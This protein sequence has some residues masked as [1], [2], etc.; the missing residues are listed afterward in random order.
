V[1]KVDPALREEQC[2]RLAAVKAERDGVQVTTGLAALTE[3][4]GSDGPLMEPIIACV[5]ACATVGEIS[6]ALRSVWGEY[7]EQVVV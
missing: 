1:L 2:R 6:D 5:E 4:A 7:T 3:A